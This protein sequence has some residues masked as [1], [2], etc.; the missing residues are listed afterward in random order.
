MSSRV[1][2]SALQRLIDQLATDAQQTLAA[3]E[4]A[5]AA[6]YERG[7]DLASQRLQGLRVA[8]GRALALQAGVPPEGVVTAFNRGRDYQ[9]RLVAPSVSG[10]A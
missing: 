4:E 1:D 5:H 9:D 8:L 6:K 2:D 10:E 7:K 3:Y